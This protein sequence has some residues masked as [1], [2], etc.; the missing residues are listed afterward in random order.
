MNQD[1]VDR[2]RSLAV[3]NI[4]MGIETIDTTRDA[5]GRIVRNAWIAWA[6]TTTN[7]K[8]SWLVPYDQLDEWNKEADRQI[9][10]A[11]YEYIVAYLMF[12]SS[13]GYTFLTRPQDDMATEKPYDP[14][15]YVTRG[16]LGKILSYC[17]YG[18][19]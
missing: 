16:E 6:K 19:R 8:P 18:N 10:E 11:V 2:L 5:G 14:D 17:K 4:D 1:Y 12:G 3:S 9:Y 7:P 13:K 15:E